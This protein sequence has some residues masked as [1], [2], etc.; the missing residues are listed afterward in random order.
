MLEQT[1]IHVQNGGQLNIALENGHIQAC[2]TNKGKGS[3]SEGISQTTYITEM[4]QKIEAYF[5]ETES[6][7]KAVEE[8]DKSSM[9]VLLGNMGSGKSDCSFMVAKE[10]GKQYELFLIE[11]GD[12]AEA[13][14]NSVL[15]QIKRNP[16]QKEMILFDDFLGKT[17]LNRSK[18]YLD[19]LNNLIEYITKNPNKKLILNSGITLFESAKLQNDTF[20]SYMDYEAEIINMTASSNL[21]DRGEIFIK[22]M[23]MYQLQHKICPTV[24]SEE[25]LNLILNHTNFTPLIVKQ[26]MKYCSKNE[27]KNLAQSFLDVLEKP[28]ALWGNE[29]KAL[30]EYARIYLNLLYSLSDTWIKVDYVK[31]AFLGYLKKTGIVYEETFDKTRASL[32]H[33]LKYEK[34]GTVDK[35]TFI[36]PSVMDYIQKELAESE[37]EKIIKNAVYFEQIER[38]DKEKK[39]IRL[40][41]DNV[42][43]FLRLKVLPYTFANSHIEFFNCIVVKILHYIVELNIKV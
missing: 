3:V 35:V 28:H 20:Q 38:L 30:N 37:R 21:H 33:L 22:Y 34:Y 17:T 27:E 10:Y 16:N 39:E 36:H 8:L 18:T 1:V 7:Q 4:A 40:L 25:E 42:E 12:C 6:Y 31:E 5:I 32:N 24:T 2:Q 9:V 26:V 19:C 23:D 29:M 43:K 14:I 15:K 13:E 41:F 11:G